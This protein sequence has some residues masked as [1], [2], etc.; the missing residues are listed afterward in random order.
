M[1]SLGGE[2]VRGPV[3][4]SFERRTSDKELIAKYPEA[5]HISRFVVLLQRQNED[6]ANEEGMS[7]CIE[8]RA[9]R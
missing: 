2:P 3:A 5:P 4:L 1:M 8:G 9:R 7:S 6:R